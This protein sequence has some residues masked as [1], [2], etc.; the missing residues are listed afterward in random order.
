M[1]LDKYSWTDR[2][3][4]LK[5]RYGISWQLGYG[6]ISRIGQ[7]ISPVLLFTNEV[8][9]KVEDALKYYNSIFKNSSID[10]IER[11]KA[12]DEDVEGK[13]MHSQ[14][15]LDNYVLMAM[16]SSKQLEYRFNEGIS[17]VVD[18]DTQQQI[19]FYWDKL[20][21][22]GGQ[23]NQCGWLKDRYGVSWQ[24][25]PTIL[26]KLLADPSKADRVN[27]A[28]MKMKKLEIDKLVKA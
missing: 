16:E 21:N 6:D 4:W 11:Y 13:I 3:G 10:R 14:F 25:I 15:K 24:I 26:P 27:N 20:T 9:G 2:Y 18:C 17:L 1:P 5:D 7:K 19:D 23:E 28:I 12:N 8:F 22:N